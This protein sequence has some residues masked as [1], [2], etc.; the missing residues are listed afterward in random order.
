MSKY[1]YFIAGLPNLS[2]DG[3]KPPYTVSGFKE[4]LEKNLTKADSRLL[5]ILFL[6]TEKKNLLEQL[7]HLD[8]ELDPEGKITF[9][10]FNVLISGLKKVIDARKNIQNLKAQKAEAEAAR[11]EIL[12]RYTDEYKVNIK[13]PAPPLPFWNR[14]RRIPAYFVKFAGMYLESMEKEE[15]TTV[16]WEDRLSSMYYEYAMKRSNAFISSWFEMN[17]NIINIYTALTCRKYKL[18]RANYIVGD[19]KVSNKLRT[20]NARDFE[21]TETLEYLPAVLRIAEETDLLQREMKTDVLRWE[22]LD[23]Q[24]LINVFGIES[25]MTY[26]L[27]IEMLEYWS[28]LDKVAGDK[29]FRQLVGTMKKGS[30]HT[31]EEFKRNNKK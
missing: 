10:E 31:L 6:K 18:D 5:N 25:I 16:P 27:K 11:D 22:W 30:K 19:T 3:G 14:N 17:L 4:E 28:S 20:S 23:E 15:V 12:G 7:Q 21:L 24:V 9:D 13:I 29:A 26:M 8:Y 2:F 1:Y